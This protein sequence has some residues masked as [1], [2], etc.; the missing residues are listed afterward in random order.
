MPQILIQPGNPYDL[1]AE[2]LEDLVEAIREIYPDNEIRLAY[3]DQ[4][5]HQVTLYEV[6]TVWIPAASDN[7]ALLL[8][9]GQ[10]V[11][12]AIRRFRGEEQE[13]NDQGDETQASEIDIQYKYRPKSI[14]ILG[15]TGEVLKSLVVHSPHDEPEDITVREKRKPPRRRPPLR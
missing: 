13:Q 11:A 10:A 1:Q 2:D 8:L 4:V 14:T 15:P 5:G 3:N 12:W 6:V 9:V 7:A